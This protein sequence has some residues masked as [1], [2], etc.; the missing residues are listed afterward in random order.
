MSA[1][2]A[3]GLGTLVGVGFVLVLTRGAEWWWE[4][5]RAWRRLVCRVR[6]HRFP[7]E[8]PADTVAGVLTR[9]SHRLFGRRCLRC[10]KRP[11]G[12]RSWIDDALRDMAGSLFVSRVVGPTPTIEGGAIVYDEA[13]PVFYEPDPED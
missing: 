3:F 13:V 2:T 8:P 10:G 5:N 9:S 6:G 7:P 4:G 12:E 1:A 11:D